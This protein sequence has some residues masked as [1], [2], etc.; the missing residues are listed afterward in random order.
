MEYHPKKEKVNALSHGMGLLVALISCPFLLLN[1][2]EIGDKWR[3]VGVLVYCISLLMVYT[4]SSLYHMTTEPVKKFRLRILDHVSIYYLI[5]G[6][7]TPFLI[8]FLPETWALV[9]LIGLWLVSLIGTIFKLFFTHRFNLVSTLAYVSMGWVAVFIIKPMM[10]VLPEQV[11]WLIAAGGA[12]YT[13][14][15][16]FY[17]WKRLFYH[18]AIWHLFVM[19]GSAFHFMAVWYSLPVKPG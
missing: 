11:L 16:L 6:S 17:L 4:S 1:A 8:L 10:R 14:G 12:C 9:Y 15:V 3:V 7:Y 19:G 5:A 18:H 2:F 13:I